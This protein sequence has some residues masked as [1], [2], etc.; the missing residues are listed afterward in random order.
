MQR[1]SPPSDF[2]AKS[3]LAPYGEEECL[4]NPLSIRLVRVSLSTCSSYWERCPSGLQG[5]N[6]ESGSS[7]IL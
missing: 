2:F 3:M 5:G 4:I 6:L 7:M 1:R